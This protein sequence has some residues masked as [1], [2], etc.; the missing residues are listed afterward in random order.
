MFNTL[1]I[2]Q[3]LAVMVCALLAIPVLVGWYGLH[4]QEA[5]SATSPP[6]TTTAWSA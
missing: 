4:T 2:A 3:R 1:T 6:P 5:Y